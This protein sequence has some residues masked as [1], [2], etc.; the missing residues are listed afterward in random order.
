MVIDPQIEDVLRRQSAV[1]KEQLAEIEGLRAE[2]DRLARVISGSA[3]ALRVLQE[4][5]TNRGNPVA[6]IMRAAESAV[7]YERSKPAAIT[8]NAGISLYD[9]LER[10]RLERQQAKVIDAKSDSAS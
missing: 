5:Y 3:D 7:A 4:I 6:T 2:V 9:V 1:I 10:K 8:V